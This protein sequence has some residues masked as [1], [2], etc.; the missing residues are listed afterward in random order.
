MARSLSSGEGVFR[1]PRGL[2]S[3]RDRPRA[4]HLDAAAADRAAPS[5]GPD[6]APSRRVEGR[7]IFLI[8]VARERE[9]L[10]RADLNQIQHRRAAAG[11]DRV[12][13]LFEMLGAALGPGVVKSG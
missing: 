8:D 11:V 4:R 10:R 5:M 7:A 13:Q 3:V 12:T 6:A 2:A 1:D 9:A